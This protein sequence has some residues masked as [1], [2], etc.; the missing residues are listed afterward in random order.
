MVF[1]GWAGNDCS[2]ATLL[3]TRE[4]PPFR[5]HLPRLDLEQRQVRWFRTALR[6]RVFRSP[7]RT[8]GGRGGRTGSDAPPRG[9]L[10]HLGA[11]RASADGWQSARARPRQVG[12]DNK[13]RGC[14]LVNVTVRDVCHG[15]QVARRASI[16]QLKTQRPVQME[17]TPASRKAVQTCC[18]RRCCRLSAACRND[19][20]ATS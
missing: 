12:I 17:V 11:A 4:K 7:R 16:M 6:R 2:Q 5:Q 20:M 10:G 3:K 15:N 19:R 8:A 18:G 9:G 1:I 13:L 14:G